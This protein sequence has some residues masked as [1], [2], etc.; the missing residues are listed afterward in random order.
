M[1][2]LQLEEKETQIQDNVYVH[3]SFRAFETRK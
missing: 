3:N 2:L 1:K